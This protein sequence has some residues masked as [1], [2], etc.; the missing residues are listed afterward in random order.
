MTEQATPGNGVIRI[1]RRFNGPHDSGNG[2]YSAGLAAASLGGGETRGVEVTLRAA[3]PLDRTLRVAPLDDGV[4]VYTDDAATRILIMQAQPRELQPPDIRPPSLE[5]AEHATSGYDMENHVLAHC[6]VCGP[7]RAEGDGLR[8]FASPVAPADNPN[9]TPIFASP[10]IPADDLAG[11]DDLVLPE[12]VWAA[13]DCPGAF[14]IDAEPI[15]LGRM[16]T[17]IIERP[18]AGEPLVV[19]A[20][21]RGAER[22]KHYASTALFTAEGQLLAFSEQTWISIDAHAPPRG[23]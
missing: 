7:A 2:G 13:L 1:A 6:F 22:R 5:A 23:E 21:S 20:W 3:V 9:A 15:L 8:I 10:W 19:V 11:D 12:H 14:A 16:A 18:I 4:G 17:Q